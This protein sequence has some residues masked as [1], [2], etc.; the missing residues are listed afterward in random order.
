MRVIKRLAILFSVSIC[1]VACSSHVEVPQPEV[2][3]LATRQLPPEQTYSRLRW[4]RPAEVLPAARIKEDSSHVQMFPISHYS[5]KNMKLKEAILVFAALNRYKSHCAASIA[6][7]SISLD[8]VGT[9]HEIARAIEQVAGISV[10]INH[11]KKTVRF[12]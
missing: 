7:K 1:F 8:I 5:V 11:E 3:S 12:L 10:F 2:F 6:D 9:Q 4:V